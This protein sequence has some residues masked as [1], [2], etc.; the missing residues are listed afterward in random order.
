VL[1]NRLSIAI[2]IFYLQQVLNYYL[3][4]YFKFVS[5]NKN[6]RIFWCIF[7][8]FH[9]D[10]VFLTLLCEG[11]IEIAWV[12]IHPNREEMSTCELRVE[13]WGGQFKTIHRDLPMVTFSTPRIFTPSTLTT[14]K[15]HDFCIFG[16]AKEWK[17][18]GWRNFVA[19]TLRG[20]PTMQ[21]STLLNHIW[22]S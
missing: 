5:F 7:I 10:I 12:W 8:S 16:V 6:M 20:I 2:F 19:W 11:Y 18:V 13:I 4:K 3:L 21:I 9:Q 17:L 15:K 22:G 1:I 14:I